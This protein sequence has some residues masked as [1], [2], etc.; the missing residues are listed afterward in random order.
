MAVLFFAWHRTLA[1]L[2]GG[3]EDAN[4]AAAMNA[5]KRQLLAML[6]GD[7]AGYSRLLAADEEATIKTLAAHRDAISITV[8]SHHGRLVDFTGDN[9]LSSGR[10]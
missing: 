5:P 8:V 7:V 6:S 9:F 1:T 10:R 3:L 2:I 4:I